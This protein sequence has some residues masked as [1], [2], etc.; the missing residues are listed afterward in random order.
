M[1][2]VHNRAS[3]MG[4]PQPGHQQREWCQ[5]F[6]VNGLQAAGSL[7]K[8]RVQ[9]QCLGVSREHKSLHWAITG[10]MWIRLGL[11]SCVRQV[12]GSDFANFQY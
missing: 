10:Y 6:S 12:E 7:E 11:W 2:A 1:G 8:F 4:W 9:R 3:G 5:L